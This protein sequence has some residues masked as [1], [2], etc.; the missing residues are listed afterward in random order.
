MTIKIKAI[1]QFFPAVLV[2][3]LYKINHLS[4]V[5]VHAT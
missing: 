3:V 5:H 2:N 4:K 1:E